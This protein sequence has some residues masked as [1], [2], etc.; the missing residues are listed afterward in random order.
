MASKCVGAVLGVLMITTMARGDGACCLPDDSCVQVGDFVECFNLSGTF[1]GEGTDCMTIS[2]TAGACCF[3]G[4]ACMDLEIVDC[5][6]MGGTFQGVPTNCGS[7]ICPGP[8]GACCL[9]N[10]QCLPGTSQSLCEN[11]LGGT[12]QGDDT[13]CPGPTCTVEPEACCLRNGTCVDVSSVDCTVLGGT[14]QGPGS[15][16]ATIPACTPVCSEDT[17]GDG[18]VGILDFLDVL[19]TW[20]PCPAPCNSDIDGDGIVG[21]L[22]FLAILAAWGPCV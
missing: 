16:C 11:E 15:T 13:M 20:G 14:P 3:T 2:C 5:A 17:D 22:D 1:F 4:G 7:T 21:V 12:Y 10:D 6:A 9:P 8:T 19:A 18:T